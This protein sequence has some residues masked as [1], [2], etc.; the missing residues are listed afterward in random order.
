MRYPDEHKD[1]VRKNIIREAS[2]A[3]RGSG[4]DGISIPAL[5]KR[6]GLTH[7]GF[8]S[9]FVDRDELVSEAVRHAAQETAA[10]VFESAPN[11]GEALAAYAS[12]QHVH[13]PENGCVVAALGAEAPR[14]VAPVRR[15][16]SWAAAGLLRLVQDKLDCR[17]KA[18]SDQA[19]EIASRLVGA[20]VLARLLDDPR[21]TS[22]L[23]AIAR[24]L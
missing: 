19:L 13:H 8:Y 17:A 18:P 3:L 24:R 12:E 7:G 6:V 5:M 16:F 22:R 4:L 15:A 1:T 9:H 21:L 11:L 10:G 2:R 20:I 14:Q 23:L